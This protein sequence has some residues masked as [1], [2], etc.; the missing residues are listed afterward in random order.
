MQTRVIEVDPLEDCRKVYKDA[1]AIMEEGGLVAI[2]TETVYGL[3]AD[4][5]NTEAV[6]NV[7]AVKDRPSF[8][9]LICHFPNGKAIKDYTDVPEE[10]WFTDAIVWATENGIVNGY[11]N[12]LFGPDDPVT[13]EQMAA[14]FYRYSKFAGYSLHEGSYDHFTDC[15]QVSA[16]AQQA[17]R[18]AVGN[19]LIVG[20]DNGLLCPGCHTR[21]VEFATVIQRFCETI[22]K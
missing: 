5:L 22:A 1:A 17:M 4:A 6:A 16:Y 9:P 12:S 20:M 8:D 14:I 13:R 19:G 18:W 2:P 10:I 21:R 11:G 15:D 3:G 7:F